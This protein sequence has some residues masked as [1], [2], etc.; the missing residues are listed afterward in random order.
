MLCRVYFVH[1]LKLSE[2]LTITNL[3]FADKEW[4]HW[5]NVSEATWLFTSRSRIELY[6]CQKSNKQEQCLEPFSY[7][8]SH[9]CGGCKLRCRAGLC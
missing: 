7:F 2:A 4:K 8:P 6:V 3:H 9:V 5:D 1:P